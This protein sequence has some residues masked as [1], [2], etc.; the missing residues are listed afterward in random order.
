[1]SSKMRLGQASS[2]SKSTRAICT[3]NTTSIIQ[4]L[5]ARS[6]NAR[7]LHIHFHQHYSYRLHLNWKCN[8]YFSIDETCMERVLAIG[9]QR[10]SNELVEGGVEGLCSCFYDWLAS[11]NLKDKVTPCFREGWHSSQKYLTLNRSLL[12]SLQECRPY[13]YTCRCRITY[14]ETLKEWK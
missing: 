14:S 13:Y 5:T 1:M 7:R 6:L 2:S 4:R 8:S 9:L 10:L 11:H 12:Q 3:A